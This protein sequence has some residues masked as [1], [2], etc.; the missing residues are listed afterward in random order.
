MENCSPRLARLSNC[1]T[2]ILKVP[3]DAAISSFPLLQ[4]DRRVMERQRP[5]RRLST[6]HSPINR[7]SFNCFFRIPLQGRSRAG[8]GERRAFSRKES[9]TVP[10]DYIG[11]L[12]H[13]EH[14]SANH[15]YTYRAN[16]L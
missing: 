12:F 10:R 2:T 7:S 16:C 6:N 11:I 14:D 5:V 9:R 3:G 4:N 8:G 15:R 1:K 13:P